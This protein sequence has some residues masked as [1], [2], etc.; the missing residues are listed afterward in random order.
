MATA[1]LDALIARNP[2]TGAELGRVAVTPAGRG[3]RDRRA[4]TGGPGGLGE[5][6]L[7]ASA[8]AS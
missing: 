5:S 6:P 4:G 7:V 3:R 8:E 1:T 2:A